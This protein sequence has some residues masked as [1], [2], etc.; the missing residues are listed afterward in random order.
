MDV[1]ALIL[2]LKLAAATTAVLL[3]VGLPLYYH[4]AR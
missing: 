2:S 3:L 1:A 4:Y